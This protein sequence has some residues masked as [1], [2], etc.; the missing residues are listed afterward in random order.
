[1]PRPRST[2][3]HNNFITF[4]VFNAHYLHGLAKLERSETTLPCLLLQ[5]PAPSS[6]LAFIHPRIQNF[7][8]EHRLWPGT[9]SMPAPHSSGGTHKINEHISR[10]GEREKKTRAGVLGLDVTFRN[11]LAEGDV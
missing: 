5:S 3:L 1:M 10:G 9:D 7:F 11:P 4:V 2:S 6:Y 8:T